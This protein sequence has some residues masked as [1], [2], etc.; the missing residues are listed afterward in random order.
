MGLLIDYEFHFQLSITFPFFIIILQTVMIAM[1]PNTGTANFSVSKK[2]LS[3][4]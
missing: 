3:M 4:P 1:A 2:L